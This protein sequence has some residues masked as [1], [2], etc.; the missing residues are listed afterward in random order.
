MIML[1]YRGGRRTCEPK[2]RFALRKTSACVRTGKFVL[3]LDRPVEAGEGAFCR[4][5]SGEAKLAFED[6]DA[7]RRE[8]V[9]GD[10]GDVFDHVD[11]DAP[12]PRLQEDLR[13]H[14][15]GVRALPRSDSQ[16]EA[17]NA[18]TNMPFGTALVASTETRRVPVLQYAGFVRIQVSCPSETS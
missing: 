15:D 16:L 5:A 6:A 18:S 8:D 17:D 1:G 3:N 14:S 7:S 10:D 4:W 11:S 2:T 13:K 9:P 12:S